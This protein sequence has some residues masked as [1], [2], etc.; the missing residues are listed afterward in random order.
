MRCFY[1]LLWYDKCMITSIVLAVTLLLMCKFAIL[2][3]LFWK[4]LHNQ[5]L[6][7]EH[8]WIRQG[9]SLSIVCLRPG[10]VSLFFDT[11]K[12]YNSLEKMKLDI[13]MPRFM[14]QCIGFQFYSVKTILHFLNILC[15][16]VESMLKALLVKLKQNGWHGKKKKL[17][18]NWTS[19]LVHGTPMHL[20]K[21]AKYAYSHSGI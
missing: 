17:C 5:C 21:Y 3:H 10:P 15:D 13:I 18:E 1:L 19:H 12:F 2:S 4:M 20:R 16:E 8:L 7:I 6:V 11:S 9:Q 14:L